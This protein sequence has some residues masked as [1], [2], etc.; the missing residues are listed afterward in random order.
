VGKTGAKV[1]VELFIGILVVCHK[2][3]SVMRQLLLL[4]LGY[5]FES[6]LHSRC[7]TPCKVP[8]TVWILQS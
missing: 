8:V 6:R 2:E 5:Y 4:Q 1:D 3:V 7:I